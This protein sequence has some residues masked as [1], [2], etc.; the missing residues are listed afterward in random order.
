MKI[1]L[2]ILTL[3]FV[4]ILLAGAFY[5]I[6]ENTS[7]LSN[8]STRPEGM[9]EFGEG[10]RPPIPEGGFPERRGRS[11]GGHHNESASLSRG[12]PQLGASLMKISIIAVIVL[13]L[14]F[15]LTRFKKWKRKKVLAG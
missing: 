13:A 5:L 15:L 1:T 14:Q 12:L 2:K 8:L 6:V 3:L 4:G 9:P 7:L 11:E 10:E